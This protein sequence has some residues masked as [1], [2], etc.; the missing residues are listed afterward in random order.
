MTTSGECHI[1]YAAVVIN[2]NV[3]QART[4]ATGCVLVSHIEII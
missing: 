4:G 1:G 3:N 2:L